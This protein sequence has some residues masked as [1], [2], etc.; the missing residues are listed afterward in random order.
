MAVRIVVEF[1]SDEEAKAFVRGFLA[2]G[3]V[4]AVQANTSMSK[5]FGKVTAAY[6]KPSKF[7]DSSDGHRGKKT[8]SAWTRGRKYGW[9]VC[10][11]CGKPTKKWATG[12]IWHFSMGYNLLPPSI[13]SID[14]GV[15]STC[16]W[17]EEELEWKPSSS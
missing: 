17:T 9:W 16:E 15:R 12:D 4:M 3:Y 1:E 7:C 8:A 11:I 10:A 13:S 5:V 14:R 2:K 6:K